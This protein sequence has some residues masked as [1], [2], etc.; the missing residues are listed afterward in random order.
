MRARTRLGFPIYHRP[1]DLVRRG[2]KELSGGE[3]PLISLFRSGHTG[4]MG[5]AQETTRTSRHESRGGVEAE[6]RET[7]GWIVPAPAG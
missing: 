3:N 6:D 5:L 2:L 4:N 7:Q 1:K